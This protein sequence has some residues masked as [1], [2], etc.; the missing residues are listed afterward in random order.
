MVC[1]LPVGY[2]PL[3]SLGRYDWENLWGFYC[4]AV[5]SLQND[6]GKGAGRYDRWTKGC[7]KKN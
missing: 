7:Y 4:F 6:R 1:T 2:A 3:A 5:A